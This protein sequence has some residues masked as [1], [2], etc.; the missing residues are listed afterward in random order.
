M[1]TLFA[2]LA[3]LFFLI[4]VPLAA[5]KIPPNRLYGF[6]TPRTVKDERVWYPTNR[7]AGRNGIVFAMAL[8]LS[9]ALSGFGILGGWLVPA[10]VLF[11][12]GGLMSTFVSASNIVNQVDKG[13]PLIDYRSS[14]ERNRQH[15][16][17]KARDKLLD[18]LRKE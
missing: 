4:S 7:I 11:F 18:K 5:G 13:G 16:A 3:L 17:G 8:A 14:F 15:D 10:L 9:A 1:T 12:L 6:R 2:G